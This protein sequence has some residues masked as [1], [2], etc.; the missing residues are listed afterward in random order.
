MSKSTPEYDRQKISITF[1]TSGTTAVDTT[2]TQ[3]NLLHSIL[4]VTHTWTPA[5]AGASAGSGAIL[6]LIDG[7]GNVTRTFAECLTGTTTLLSGDF[8]VFPNDVLRYK[9]TARAGDERCV[10]GTTVTVA[11][12]PTATVILYKY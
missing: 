7:D 2:L 5:D 9:M 4:L 3:A 1:A 10:S 12:R 8:M 6:Q 11:Q